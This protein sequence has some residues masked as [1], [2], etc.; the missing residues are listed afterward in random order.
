MKLILNFKILT[1]LLLVILFLGACEKMNQKRQPLTGQWDELF[2]NPD[3]LSENSQ[4]KPLTLNHALIEG[5]DVSGV[6]LSNATFEDTGWRNLTGRK[7]QF[8]NVTIRNSEIEDVDFSSSILIKVIFENVTFVGSRFHNSTFIDVNFINCKL[9]DAQMDNFRG[10]SAIKAKNV[11]ITG[12]KMENIT[13]SDG[14]GNFII[15][16]SVIIDSSF[17]DMKLPSSLEIINSQLDYFDCDGSE[18]TA[19][20]VTDSQLKN[21]SVQDSHIGKVIVTN[22]TLNIS[23]ARAFIEEVSVFETNNELL[24]FLGATVGSASISFCKNGGLV[25]FTG[26]KFKSLKIDNCNDFNLKVPEIVG[27]NFGIS[28]SRVKEAKFYDM[29][30][31]HLIIDNV[32]FTGETNFDGAQAKKSE[33]HN[34]KKSPGA[35]IT[36]TGSN[37]RLY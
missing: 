32:E 13:F 10:F 15:E 25:G 11:K 3:K 1:I 22:S 36:A 8:T 27:K 14:Q 4:I 34:I 5:Y 2:K 19:F 30:V 9:L 37:I 7:A 16:K 17:S 29:V 35:I 31:D 20:T 12:S 21:T 23:F 18:L 28:N 6:H 26:M 33:I 24:G